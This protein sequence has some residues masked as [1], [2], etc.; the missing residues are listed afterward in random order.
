MMDR[1]L[2]LVGS[3]VF[4]TAWVGGMVALLATAM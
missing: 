2:Y 3:A 1:T 4:T